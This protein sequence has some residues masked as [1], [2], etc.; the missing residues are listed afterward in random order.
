MKLLAE[1]KSFG[2]KAE[3][4]LAS[5]ASGIAKVV[6]AIQKE[7]PVIEGVEAAIYPPAVVVTKAAFVALGYLAKAANDANAATQQKLQ[8]LG[9]DTQEI[10]DFKALYASL[11]AVGAANGVTLPAPT[12]VPAS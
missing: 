11:H 2:L 12:L 4:V 3:H 9:L 7:E 5:I 8:D 10:A 6:P 1:L